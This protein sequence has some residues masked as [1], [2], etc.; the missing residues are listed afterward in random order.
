MRRVTHGAVAGGAGEDRTVPWRRATWVSIAAI[1]A[2][3]IAVTVLYDALHM[4]PD[5]D[6]SY[7]LTALGAFVVGIVA[8][9]ATHALGFRYLGGLSWRQIGFGIHWKSGSPYA[10]ARS[11]MP[12]SDYRA[13]V[14]LP[15]L[16]T[17]LAPLAVGLVAGVPALA[18]ASAVL[19][20]AASG[21][22]LVLAAIRDLPGDAMVQDHPS[23]PGARVTFGGS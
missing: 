11:P 20:G 12:A 10:H 22:W 1:V 17:G 2:C 18:L 9:E 15:G 13:A 6:L 8:H 5:E 7:W 16:V 4:S 3:V 23:E 21:D 14:V 19:I